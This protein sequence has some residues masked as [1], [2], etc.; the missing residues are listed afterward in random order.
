[1]LRFLSAT[2]LCLYIST[3][4]LAQRLP[5]LNGSAISLPKPAYSREFK[6][7]CA[8]GQVNVK[9]TVSPSGSVEDASA[10]SGDPILYD[11]AVVAVKKAKFRFYADAPPI[12][13]TGLVVYN[14]PSTRNCIDGG[15]L[16]KKAISLP[17]PD[18][19]KIEQLS[20]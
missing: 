16:N 5:V 11:A 8:Y 1:M 15:V 18:L 9:V 12:K 4:V 14:F 10:T 7:L 2:S 19:S 20:S 13:R 3:V 17:S 6:D